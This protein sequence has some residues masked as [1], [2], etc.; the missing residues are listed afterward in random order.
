MLWARCPGVGP[1]RI[2]ALIR[3]F[4]SLES[5][6]Q[7]SVPQLALVCQ[8]PERLLAAVEA[9]RLL[10]GANPLPRASQQWNG[11]RRVLVPGDRRWPLAIQRS[12]PP[13]AALYWAGR[14]SLWCPLSQRHAVAV[15]GTRRPSRH[16]LSVARQIGAV[17]AQ[18]GWPVVSGLAAGIDGAVHGACLEAGGVPVGVL[19]T[20]LERAY[21]RHHAG[22]QAEVGDRGLLI[23]EL[24]PQTPVTKGSF[25]R[26]NRLQV[27]LARAVILVECPLGSG[28][29]HSAELAWR[30]GLPLWVVPADTG[31]PSAEG[32]NGL[33]AKGAAPLTNP[34]DLLTLLG[35]GPMGA[36]AARPRG[37]GGQPS[38][39][40]RAP[41]ER[42]LAAL[43]QGTS[44]EELC[45]AMA[46]PAE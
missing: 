1:Q 14:G 10:W 33:L 7:A 30:E 45:A 26:R 17:L 23:S 20:P 29:L 4:G 11:G 28:A 38:P 25:A 19:G 27:A 2:H 6:W 16:G 35:R 39:D 9:H 3:G 21:P 41:C 34:A 40:P 32:S 44:M 5:A 15:V 46:T 24:A 12:Q 13:P 37:F 43:G 36:G 18:G 8:W 31:R 22:L 42:I